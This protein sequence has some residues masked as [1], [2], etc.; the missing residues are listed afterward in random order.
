MKKL[1]NDQQ[2]LAIRLA[3]QVIASARTYWVQPD[4]ERKYTYCSLCDVEIPHHT[5]NCPV[6]CAIALLAIVT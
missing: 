1:T 5:A 6:G 4:G 2:E 3:K